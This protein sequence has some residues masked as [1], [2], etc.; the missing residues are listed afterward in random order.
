LSSD[1]Y[2]EFQH[3]DDDDISC[4]LPTWAPDTNPNIVEYFQHVVHQAKIASAIMKNFTTVKARE[5]SPLQKTKLVKHLDQSLRAWYD[6]LPKTFKPDFPVKEGHLPDGIRT[7][8]L[9][10][11]RFSY[12]ANLAAIH[13]IFGHPWNLTDSLENQ[14]IAVSE[15]AVSSTQALNE[16]S[17]N[18]VLVTRSISVDAYAPAW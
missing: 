3:I 6:D 12:Y 16:A 7:E 11:L 14:N 5:Q 2:L 1:S 4:E 18:I 10:Y 17:R 15:Q 9:M 13:S 8:Q